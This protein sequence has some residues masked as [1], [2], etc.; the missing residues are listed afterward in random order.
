MTTGEPEWLHPHVHEPNPEPPT[1]DPTFA[2]L[3]PHGRRA[4]VDVAQL[5]TLPLVVLPDCFIV[6]TGHGRSGP[7]TFVGARLDDV[8][9]SV[10]GPDLSWRH[11]DVVSADG[12]GTRVY[13][14]E[15]ATAGSRPPI[16]SYA[17]DGQPLTRAWGLV[18]LIVPSETDDALRQVKWVAEIRVDLE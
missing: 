13:A 10:L 5:E 9:R 3:L 14:N 16:L 7:F 12:F 6:S 4:T 15:L 11:A 8:L 18:R 2:V 17:V 1:A